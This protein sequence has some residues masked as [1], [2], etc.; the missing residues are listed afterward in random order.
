MANLF[1]TY[2][3]YPSK[4]LACA[5]KQD[6]SEHEQAIYLALF[7]KAKMSPSNP[8]ADLTLERDLYAQFREDVSFLKD[9]ENTIVKLEYAYI[10]ALYN[11]EADVSNLSEYGIAD[12]KAIDNHWAAYFLYQLLT[13]D[14]N[15]LDEQTMISLL[16]TEHDDLVAAVLDDL[17]TMG[18]ARCLD[19]VAKLARQR[20]PH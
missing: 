6:L 18:S 5:L 9:S 3:Y 8:S 11:D 14:E 20:N 12:F 2:D 10:E 17:S 4:L 1:D 7:L 19:E 15:Y 16:N 13:F